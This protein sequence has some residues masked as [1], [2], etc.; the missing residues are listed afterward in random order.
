MISS[1]RR[2]SGIGLRIVVYVEIDMP[3]IIK[4]APAALALRYLAR[5]IK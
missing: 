5:T 3:F 4:V 1:R 2:S